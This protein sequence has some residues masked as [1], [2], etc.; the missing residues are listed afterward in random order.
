MP[1]KTNRINKTNLPKRKGC[2][3][4][5]F[6]E[7]I[8]FEWRLCSRRHQMVAKDVCEVKCK[9]GAFGRKWYSQC[10]FNKQAPP[11]ES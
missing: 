7:V 2:C 10:K 5:D 1:E 4:K 6:K 8:K 3:N 11:D 9:E